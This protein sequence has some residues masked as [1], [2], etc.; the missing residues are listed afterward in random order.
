MA[1]A[2]PGLEI[3]RLAEN[4]L[5]PLATVTFPH[6]AHHGESYGQIDASLA[7]PRIQLDVLENIGIPCISSAQPCGG[8]CAP[9]APLRRAGKSYGY[10]KNAKNR[11]LQ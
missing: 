8:Q 11:W 6:S 1:N 10:R 2:L 7:P 3:L 9:H 5:K 4:L